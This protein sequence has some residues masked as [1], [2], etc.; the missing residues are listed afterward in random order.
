M[1]VQLESFF[2][3][4][5]F[6]GFT[7]ID[8]T[9]AFYQRIHAMITPETTVLD[10]GC[11]RGGGCEDPIPYRRDLRH[12]R[13]KAARVIGIDVDPAATD[14]PLLDEF[15][16]LEGD[17]WPLPDDSVD[18]CISDFV[19]EHVSDP[20]RFFQE[21]RRVLRPGGHVCIRTPNLL[22]YVGLLSHLM[23]NRLH[24][25]V[26][27]RAQPD[28]QE[29]DIFPTVYRC[30]T[31]GSLRRMLRRH[32]FDAV[33]YGYEA[34]PSYLRFSRVAFALGL[35]YRWLAPGFLRTCLFAYARLSR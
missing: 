1:A 30:N 7:D 22:S 28:R 11:G 18:L 21:L 19:L 4:S 3:E 26:L 16:L 24:A 5:R 20:D 12:L 9:V 27:K 13:G 35:C 25:R 34:E 15:H 23:P 10:V 33:V 31:I 17:R 14:N 8:G 29:R 2:P 6:G 32:A